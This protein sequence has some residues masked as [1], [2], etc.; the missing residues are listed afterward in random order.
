MQG[1]TV[2]S[3]LQ[4]NDKNTGH[5]DTYWSKDTDCVFKVVLNQHDAHHPGSFCKFSALAVCFAVSEITRAS[6]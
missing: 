3:P 2:A 6:R 1:G 4:L 5:S